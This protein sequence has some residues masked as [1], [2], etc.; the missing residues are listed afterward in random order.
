MGSSHEVKSEGEETVEELLLKWDDHHRSFFELAEEL[1]HSEQFID[2]TLSCGEHNFPAHKLVLSVCSP[3]FR[4]LFLRNPCK[5]PIVVLK[6]VSSKY[7]K[8]LL[9]YMY[10]GEVSCPQED[11]AGLLK[12]ARSLQIRGLVELERKREAE[13]LTNSLTGSPIKRAMSDVHDGASTTS[14]GEMDSREGHN[15][16]E[17]NIDDVRSRLNGQLEIQP[18]S[19][20]SSSSPFQ[21]SQQPGGNGANGHH[22][23]PSWLDEVRHPG[24]LTSKIAAAATSSSTDMH[25]DRGL[26]LATPSDL[27]VKDIDRLYKSS[28]PGNGGTDLTTHHR[29]SPLNPPSRPRSR[30]RP[31]SASNTMTAA[32]AASNAALM[33]AAQA[34]GMPASALDPS[35]PMSSMNALLAAAQVRQ[36]TLLCILILRTNWDFS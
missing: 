33:A 1:C 29:R 19:Q 26:P 35:D 2:V 32:T 7:M 4:H 30:T 5:H 12:T 6:D 16:G 27:R 17:F 18:I 8:L 13:G 25:P 3:Y 14:C 22:P 21:S 31:G 11:L 34:A 36:E 23:P 15:G 28:S 9:M 24:N 20:P 10:R